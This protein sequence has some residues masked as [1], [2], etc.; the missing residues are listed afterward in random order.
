M[1]IRLSGEAESA[2]NL[3]RVE[4]ISVIDGHVIEH[5]PLWLNNDVVTA[6]RHSICRPVSWLAPSP[7]CFLQLDAI[8]HLNDRTLVVQAA[9]SF[10]EE[11]V[12]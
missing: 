5:V 4:N 2:I 8:D 9:L 1:N 3:E 6:H 12:S 11:V 7:Y 10:E